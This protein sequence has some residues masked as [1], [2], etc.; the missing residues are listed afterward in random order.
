[1]LCRWHGRSFF[2]SFIY[3]SLGLE[4]Q[5]ELAR[6]NVQNTYIINKALVDCRDLHGRE[7]KLLT[8]RFENEKVSSVF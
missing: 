3:R 4:A 6:M 2:A 7:E 1:M 8:L 5:C